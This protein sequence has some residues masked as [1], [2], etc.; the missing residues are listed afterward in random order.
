MK[1]K[2]EKALA[3]CIESVAAANEV[4]QLKKIINESLSACRDAWGKANHNNDHDEHGNLY[5]LHLETAYAFEVIEH[6]DYNKDSH[7]DTGR[8]YLTPEEQQAILS[9]C[10]HCMAAHNAI[11]DRKQARKRLGNARR[12]ITRIGSA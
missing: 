12:A 1:N 6:G 10:P 9:V 11:Q 8:Y 4:K 3:A 5:A 2:E 7:H